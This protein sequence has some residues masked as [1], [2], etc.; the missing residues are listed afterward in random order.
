MA[1][2]LGTVSPRVA[3]IDPRRVKPPPKITEEIYRDARYRA[4]AADV[5]ARAGGKCQDPQ[6]MAPERTPSRLFADHVKELRDGG[7]PF[8][9]AN[10]LAR[11]GSCHTRKTASARAARLRSA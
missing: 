9:R 4:W 1:A 7:A 8:D 6:C 5:I 11:C 10:G 2:R 3:M